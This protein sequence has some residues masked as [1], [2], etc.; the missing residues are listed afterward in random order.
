MRI[1]YSSHSSSIELFW[2]LHKY[3]KKIIS[4]DKCGFMITNKY[5]Y[6]IFQEK[7]K[8]FNPSENIILSE[9]NILKEANK[10]KNIDF[11][12]ISDWEEKL[13]DGSLWNSLIIDRRLGFKVSAQYRQCYDSKYSHEMLLKILQ[14]SINAINN[15][16]EKI[17][18]DAVL[19][20]NAVTI[21]DYLYYLIARY[22]KIPYLQLKLTRINNY[23]SWFSNPYGISTHIQDSFQDFLNN[24]SN[25]NK[26]IYEEAKEFIRSSQNSN[27]IYEG[28]INKNSKERSFKNLKKIFLF[29]KLIPK[30]KNIFSNIF[31][32]EPHYP[33]NLA[34]IFEIK[35]LRF[36]RK[37]LLKNIFDINNS[38]NFVKNNKFK[39]VFFPLN[40]EPEVALL[41]YGRPYRN[42]I[43]T[44]RN[45]ASSIPVGWK[46]IVKEHPNSFGY[47]NPTYYKKLKQIP[48][49]LIASSF[50]NANTLIRNSDLVAVVYG[51]IGLE[52]ILMKKPL[53]T[54]CDCP[55][56]LFSEKM[57]MN[58]ENLWKLQ[59]DIKKLITNY[60]FEE[61]QL[62]SFIASHIE[63]SE[64]INLFTDLLSKKSRH[65]VSQS[66]SLTMQYEKLA[67]YTKKR[68]IDEIQRISL[69]N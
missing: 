52:A 9:W 28:A 50:C 68:V 29:N 41:G 58:S 2:Y 69:K 31:I 7:V 65:K 38:K 3:L 14:S 42:Q 45:L 36:F 16:F 59:K 63:C 53:I 26:L 8:E 13:N 23:V 33:Y 66:I 57:V 21:Y 60:S 18:P 5:S 49:V 64:R 67:A 48:N 10:I 20:L 15:H 27:L 55:Y 35:F 22:R 34:P 62:I 56:S 40:T 47:R 51:T 19:G 37:C 32:E 12:Y 43:E 39:Y 25:K 44:V 6:K 54:F 24:G 11:N 17:N 46:L 30:L 61:K 4:I 1:I